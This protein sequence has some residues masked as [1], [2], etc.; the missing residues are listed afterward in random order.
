MAVS[1]GLSPPRTG[2]ILMGGGARAA[3]QA[4][5]LSAVVELLAQVNPA[6]AASAQVASTGAHAD[7]SAQRAA[8]VN[9]FPIIIGTSAGALNASAYAC[10]ADRPLQ[11]VRDIEQT[12]A[13]IHASDVY[14]SDATQ[15]MRTGARWLGMLA[16]GWLVREAPRSL[17]DN[18]PLGRL[19]GQMIDF[20]RLR[21]LLDRQVV[22]SLAIT[23]SSYSSGQHVTFYESRQQ[24]QA[25]YRTQRLAIPCQIARHHLLASSSLPFIFPAVRLPIGDRHEWFGD[26]SMR[27]LAPISPAI[28]LG[29]DRVLVIGVGQL[30]QGTMLPST[31]NGWRSYPSL[32]Q[33]AGHAMSSI[34]L[35]GLAMDIERLNRV[36]RTVSLI[37]PERRA[38]QTLRPMKVLVISPSRRL[39]QMAAPHIRALPRPI[40]ALLGALGATEKR[41]AAMAS[42]LLFEPPYTRELLTLGR[43]DTLARR[44]EVLAF[45]NDA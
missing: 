9:P 19:L 28:H 16:L 14:R 29:A 44:D 1:Q 33:V 41:G 10:A 4:G 21:E 18:R 26:G 37:P 30:Q 22:Q 23:A 35:D 15:V 3:Y 11:A 42:Y 40:R 13:N 34:F 12:W 27:Q 38:E 25:W 24:H 20:D 36:N 32:A 31:I 7:A 39:D 45:F 5:V 2:L 17:L 6:I 43:E 8:S